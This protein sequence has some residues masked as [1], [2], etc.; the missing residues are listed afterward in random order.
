MNRQ[1]SPAPS[2]TSTNSSYKEAA[3]QKIASAYNYLPAAPWNNSYVH[4]ELNRN[5]RPSTTASSSNSDGRGPPQPPPPPY[6]NLS[7]YPAAAVTRRNNAWQTYNDPGRL[8]GPEQSVA[9]AYSTSAPDS[10]SNV[11]RSGANQSQLQV[12]KR[13]ELW[14]QRWERA[15]E[16]CREK[17]VVLRSWRVG[18]D[19]ADECV[20]IV[21][22]ATREETRQDENGRG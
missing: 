11:F 12:N 5:P 18:G 4:T 6:R 15:R 16:Y 7:S 10:S 20:R 21:E 9:R 14:Q 2:Y 1:T 17:G 22:R 8:S 3:K 13:L 19:V